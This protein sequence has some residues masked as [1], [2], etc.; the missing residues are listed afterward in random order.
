MQDSDPRPASNRRLTLKSITVSHFRKSTCND[1]TDVWSKWNYDGE[2][3]RTDSS[4]GVLDD[5]I[6]KRKKNRVSK[7]QNAEIFWAD[8]TYIVRITKP[9]EENP[10]WRPKQL[11]SELKLGYTKRTAKCMLTIHFYDTEVG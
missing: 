6:E 4:W 9:E 7:D 3:I 1:V 11:L 10:Y 2:A 8:M 5:K